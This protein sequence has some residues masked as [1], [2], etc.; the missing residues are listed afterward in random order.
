MIYKWS[1]KVQVTGGKSFAIQQCGIFYFV[2]RK[3]VKE[4]YNNMCLHW[5]IC[6]RCIKLTS[7][8]DVLLFVTGNSKFTCLQNLRKTIVYWHP[9]RQHVHHNQLAL[10]YEIFKSLDYSWTNTP[11][12][13]VKNQIARERVYGHNNIYQPG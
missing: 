12:V 2:A 13:L 7:I 8:F 3:E 6:N 1:T 4:G 9:V 10:K 5:S 11:V